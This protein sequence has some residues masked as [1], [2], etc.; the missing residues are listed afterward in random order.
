VHHQ[1][2]GE[3]ARALELGERVL[4][5]AQQA[6]WRFGQARAHVVLQAANLNLGA[7]AA[8]RLHVAQALEQCRGRP[9]RDPGPHG[10]D[11]VVLSHC[12]GALAEHVLGRPDRA[13]EACRQALVVAL[14]TETPHPNSVAS[15]HLYEAWVRYQRREPRE[16]LAAAEAGIAAVAEQAEY[17]TAL[18][19]RLIGLCAR[20]ELLG[21]G[22]AVHELRQAIAEYEASGMRVMTTVFLGSLARGLAAQGALCDALETIDT[23]LRHAEE[24]QEGYCEP[25]LHRTRGDVLRARDPGEAEACYRRALAQAREQGARAWQLRAAVGLVRLRGTAELPALR[26]LCRDFSEGADTPDLREAR[27]L[28]EA[29]PV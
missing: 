18:Q 14:E 1:A 4:G 6:S 11:I 5:L 28:C 2:H 15:A 22:A 26:A 19:C 23:A 21:E 20:G 10:A 9:P 25:D 8:T 17:W 7:F 13:L 24:L 12:H 27:S 3:Y 29:A 16:A